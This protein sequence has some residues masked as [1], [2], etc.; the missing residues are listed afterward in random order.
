MIRSLISIPAGFSRMNLAPFLALTALGSF[1]WNTVLVWVGVAARESWDII[2][3]YL[4]SY[5]GITKCILFAGAGIALFLFSKENVP[6][7][8]VA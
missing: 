2:V 8:R 5:S 4:E 1:L 6:E 7:N 3:K